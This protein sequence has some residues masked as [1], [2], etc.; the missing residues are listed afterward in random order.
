MQVLLQISFPTPAVTWPPHATGTCCCLRRRCCIS[1]CIRS[2]CGSRSDLHIFDLTA[3]QMI[4]DLSLS[5]SLFVC[6]ES[7]AGLETKYVL[8]SCVVLFLLLPLP[9]LRLLPL[10]GGCLYLF[11]HLCYCNY[12]W[13]IC[14]SV[15]ALTLI[16]C[17]M[18]VHK[19]KKM[20]VYKNIDFSIFHLWWTGWTGGTISKS[21]V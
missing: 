16:C 2:S 12:V 8:L 15:D 9:R 3:R 10:P 11:C 7:G 1:I 6:C 19:D 20:R 14:I 4:A 17:T 5:Y 13:I 18:L 21:R